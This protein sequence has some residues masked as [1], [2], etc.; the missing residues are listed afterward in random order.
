MRLEFDR[1]TRERVLI[2]VFTMRFDFKLEQEDMNV[3]AINIG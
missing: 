3:K 1:D 2:M